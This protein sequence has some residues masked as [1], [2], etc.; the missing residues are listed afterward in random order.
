LNQQARTGNTLALFAE[1]HGS[2][3]LAEMARELVLAA[4][5]LREDFAAPVAAIL[6]ALGHDTEG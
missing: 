3:R 1:E 5:N 2:E 6:A 4:E